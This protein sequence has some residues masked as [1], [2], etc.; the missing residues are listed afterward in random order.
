MTEAK[1]PYGHDV[2]ETQ[3]VR[4]RRLM[5]VLTILLLTVVSVMLVYLRV[6]TEALVQT[7]VLEQARSHAHQ[8]E[9]IRLYV[10]SFG[11]IYVPGSDDV[12][13]NPHLPSSAAG[14][15]TIAGPDGRTYVL[16][17]SPLV[18]QSVSDLMSET[19]EGNVHIGM[20]ALSPLNPANRADAFEASALEAF[21]SGATE[22]WAIEKTSVGGRTFR[23]AMPILAGEKCVTCHPHLQG[24]AG[25]PF[26]ATSVEVD[27][28]GQMTTLARGRWTLGGALVLLMLGSATGYMLIDTKL[29]VRLRQAQERLVAMA[30]TDALTGLLNRRALF[31]KLQTEIARADREAQPLAVIM[32]DLDEFKAVN[33]RLG[34]A[35]GDDMLLATAVAL[36]RVARRYDTVARLGGEEFLVVLPNLSDAAG[37]ATAERMRATITEATASLGHDISAVTASAG[38]A[39]HEPGTGETAD[40]LVARADAAM[41]AAKREGRNA[42]RVAP[43][44]V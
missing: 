33:D 7:T 23:Y 15:A 5:A 22:K 14:P 20:V 30:E 25:E 10:A 28:S 31:P 27:V 37:H 1:L 4:L 9:A 41:L 6:R 11:G 24:H 19:G 21:G 13:P 42:V 12:A 43:A 32:L 3:Y 2:P 35:A 36:S 39:V 26:A 40:Q 17:N 29:L 8:F 18:A 44:E 34:H 38:V 16:R